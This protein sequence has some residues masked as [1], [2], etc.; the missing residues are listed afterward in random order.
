M[1]AHMYK[2]LDERRKAHF[3]VHEVFEPLYNLH[4]LQVPKD[5]WSDYASSAGVFTIGEV[6][7]GDPNYCGPYQKPSG[8]LDAVLNYP[9]YFQLKNSF[10]SKQT[11]RNIHDGVENVSTE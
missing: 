6:F 11:M 1:T 2:Y 7:N 5:F 3:I 8:P 9:M 10:Q 4:I